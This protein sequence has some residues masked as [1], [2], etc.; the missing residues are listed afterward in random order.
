MGE[1]YARLGKKMGVLKALREGRRVA[2]A[3]RLLNERWSDEVV[4]RGSTPETIAAFTERHAG[5]IEKAGD[6]VGMD[7]YAPK[8]KIFIGLR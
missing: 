6:K 3:V 4:A 2:S 7:A 1:K 5:V 8:G